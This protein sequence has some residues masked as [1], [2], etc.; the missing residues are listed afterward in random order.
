MKLLF[1]IFSLDGGG[2]QRVTVNLANYWAERGWKITIVTITSISQDIYALD[3]SIARISL[4][5]AGASKNI[6]DALLRNLKRVRQLRRVLLDIKPDVAVAMADNSCVTLAL[7]VRGLTGTVPA[8]S[9]RSYPPRVPTKAIWKS[10]QSLAYGQLSALVAQTPETASWLAANTNARRIEV[11]PNPIQ[12][13][14]PYGERNIEPGTVCEPER[15]VLLA[16]GRLGPEK[17]FDLLIDVF[18]SLFE[19]H[20]DWD[21]VIVG[22]G[23]ERQQLEL[24]ISA[25]GLGH[26]V[27]LPGWAGNMSD[28]YERAQLYVMSSSFEGF[29]NTLAEAMAHGLPAVS[30]DCD[31]GPRHI[32]RDGRDGFLA[33]QDDG[34]ALAAV[35]DRLMGDEDL[36]QRFGRAAYEIRDRYSLQ[37]VAQMWEGMFKDLLAQHRKVAKA[38]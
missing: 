9:I 1:F 29:P 24:T 6:G 30:F 22:E 32:I 8:G 11:I 10:V 38:S 7:A 31:V 35:L 17:R 16:A 28:W 2:A 19:R 13:P 33:P 26:C 14:L 15:K 34:P 21:L 25:K 27:F 12:W 4:G 23:A 3:P 37:R 20:P 5:M 36:R 18:A